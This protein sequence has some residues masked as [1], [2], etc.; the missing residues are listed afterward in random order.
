MKKVVAVVGPTASGKTSLSIAL[1]KRFDGEIIGADSMQIY[2]EMPVATAVPTI[3]EREGIPH[4]L[5][6]FLSPEECFSVAE[7]VQIAKSK[8]NEIFSRG[9]TPIVV[10]GTGLFINSLFQNIEF[11][12]SGRDQEYRDRLFAFA[13][14]N[15]NDALYAKLVD[16]DKEAAKKI[17]PNNLNRVV[18]GLELFHSIGTTISQQVENSTKTPSEF[19]PL[20]L[21]ITYSDREML[22]QRINQRVDIMLKNGLLDEAEQMLASHSE[23]TACQAIGHK[24]LSSYLRGETT[25]EQATDKLKMETRRYAKRQLTWFRRNEEMHW[26]YPDKEDVLEKAFGLTEVFLKGELV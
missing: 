11:V 19:T 14:E 8:I 3:G 13:M 9:K 1:A 17:H 10:G 16:V 6:E 22:Y 18:R 26:L 7:Y 23:G 5:I 2:R 12:D 20:Y 24:E 25:L 21:G 4:H 15:G